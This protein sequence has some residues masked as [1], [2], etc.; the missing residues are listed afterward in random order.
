[1]IRADMCGVSGGMTAYAST[2]GSLGF[3][4]PSVARGRWHRPAA[5]AAGRTGRA[6][7]SDDSTP[8]SRPGAVADPKA[9]AALM[10]RIAESRDKAAFAELF[11]FYAPR[12]KSY[13]LRLGAESSQADDLAQEAMLSVWRKAAMFDP[14]KAAAGTWIF[15]IARNLRIDAIR[16]EKRPELD[17]EDPALVAEPDPAA[18]RVVEL[19]QHG[20]RVRE[21]LSNLPDEQAEIV[22]LSFFADKP[23][24]AIAEE[25]GLPLGTV[26]SRLRLAYRRL[27]EELRDLQ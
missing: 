18:D 8:T 20:R 13:L 27:Q 5:P 9:M 12:L 21:A 7:T 22:R 25:L 2:L 23:H 4:R 10:L 3:G 11:Q 1:M 15:A 26:K 24:G 17:P 14:S 16:R 6:V 19:D